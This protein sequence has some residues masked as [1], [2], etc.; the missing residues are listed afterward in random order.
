MKQGIAAILLLLLTWTGC[1]I[2][3][4]SSREEYYQLENNFSV[5]LRPVSGAKSISIVTIY[6]IGEDHDPVGKSG[7]GHLIE[8]LYVTAAAGDAESRNIQT[9]MSQYPEGWNAQTGKNY[10][11]I[12]TVFPKERIESEIKDAAARMSKLNIKDSDL[13]REIPRIENELSNMYG[14][15]PALT[16]QNLA[17]DMVV[18]HH[19]NTRKGGI[20]NQIRSIDVENIHKRIQTFYKP[21]NAMMIVAGA[22]DP[23]QVK[24]AIIKTFS[25]IESG[26]DIETV[27]L[28]QKLPAIMTKSKTASPRFPQAQSHV[29]LAFRTP[30]PSDNLFPAFLVL[31]ARLQSSSSKLNPPQNLFPVCFA[32][33]DRPEVV[34]VHL[35]VPKGK[36]ANNVVKKLTNYVSVTTSGKLKRDDII[37]TKQAFGYTLGLQKYP[38]RVLANNIYGVALY[39]GMRKHF[40]IDNQKLLKKLNFVTQDEL[41]ETTKEYFTPENYATAIV[42]VK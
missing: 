8:H 3:Q 12:A 9:F 25:E 4:S 15:I 14:G 6:S 16:A 39:L 13:K 17:T 19:P 26:K 22:I 42:N 20:I 38:D 40:G 24:N 33:L 10:T 37:N 29:A 23:E 41:D 18:A 32:P 11:I 1:S 34:T 2:N 35:P 30:N 5:I 27:P 28:S 21:K 7:M 31:V 36:K